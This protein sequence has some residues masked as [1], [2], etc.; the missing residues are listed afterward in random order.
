MLQLKA[1]RYKLQRHPIQYGLTNL[2]RAACTVNNES[3]MN[4]ILGNYL[5]HLNTDHYSEVLNKSTA[6]IKVPQHKIYFAVILWH[7]NI[8]TAIQ[9]Q[10]SG[11]I[12]G[13]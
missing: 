5:F 12:G 13:T 8:S 7:C 11:T 3:T 4:R 2:H 1:F 10:F 6:L 9:I